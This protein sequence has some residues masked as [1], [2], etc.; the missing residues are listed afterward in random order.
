MANEKATE[1]TARAAE[2]DI[3]SGPELDLLVRLLRVA[4]LSKLD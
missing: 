1:G 4:S 3:R 2:Q